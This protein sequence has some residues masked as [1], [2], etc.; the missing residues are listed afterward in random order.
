MET[1][2]NKTV[3]GNVYVLISAKSG[4]TDGSVIAIYSSRE[5]ADAKRVEYEKNPIST[6]WYHVE[7][8]TVRQ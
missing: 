7:T 2:T 5:T 3:T 8:W 4:Q 6:E 1:T